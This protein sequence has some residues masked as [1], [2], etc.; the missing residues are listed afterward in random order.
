MATDNL[1]KIVKPF[2]DTHRNHPSVE[3]EM[4]LGKLKG[5]KFETDVGEDIFKRILSGLEAFGDW[6]SV[7]KTKHSIYYSDNKRFMVNEETDESTYMTKKKIV[8]ENIKLDGPLDL[9]FSVSHEDILNE[10]PSGVMMDC[11]KLRT[12]TSFVRK[13]LS[14]DM[15]V[16]GGDPD[17]L[18]NEEPEV[19]QIELEIINPKKVKSDDELYNILYKIECLLNIL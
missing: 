8:N 18:D 1:L 17:D 10:D 12:R 16:I 2:F 7:S 14:I 19:Y 15:S 11:V 13:N 9:R 5:K 4:R 3:I 6:E